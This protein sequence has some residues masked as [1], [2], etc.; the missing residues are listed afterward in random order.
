MKRLRRRLVQGHLLPAASSHG[1]TVSELSL[2]WLLLVLVLA[3]LGCS[4]APH[5]RVLDGA[6]A[7]RPTLEAWEDVLGR[8]PDSCIHLDSKYN[9]QL[10]SKQSDLPCP[11]PAANEVLGGCTNR[12]TIYV[13]SGRPEA[14]MMDSVVHEWLHAIAL[15]VYG[16]ADADHL[17]AEVWNYYDS[18][19]MPASIESHAETSDGVGACL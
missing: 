10:T 16:D 17:R 15:C 4:P 9:V 13:L 1:T 5:E 19:D 2:A 14:D 12:D 3:A 7:F 8:A 18:G 11:A 6:C